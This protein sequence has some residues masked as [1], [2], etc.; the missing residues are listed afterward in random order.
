[1]P[2]LQSLI[3]DY[4]AAWNEPDVAVRSQLVDACWAESAIVVAPNARCAGR[5]ELLA[6]IARFQRE[7]P[8]FRTV[9]THGIDAHHDCV[10]F[11]VALV[12][13]QGRTVME[14]EDF[15]EIG[16]DGRLQKITAFFGP[17]AAAAE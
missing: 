4:V 14:A 12:D 10:R 13:P 1:M 3:R 6:E 17:L 5:V 15:G 7:M 16:P 2:E 9:L 11:A 8:G